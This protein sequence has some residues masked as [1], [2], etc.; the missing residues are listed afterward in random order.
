MSS[1]TD[2]IVLGT[3]T[4]ASLA[5]SFFFPAIYLPLWVGFFASSCYTMLWE[6]YKVRKKALSSTLEDLPT[7]QYTCLVW[8]PVSYVLFPILGILSIFKFNE[9]KDV[10]ISQFSET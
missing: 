1:T 9:L 8:V 2:R 5:C 3:S 10:I 4:V 6:A 7:F